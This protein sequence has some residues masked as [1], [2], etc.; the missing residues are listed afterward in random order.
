MYYTT[1]AV[2]TGQFPNAR[3]GDI[4]LE[5][6]EPVSNGYA[7]VGRSSTTKNDPYQVH[8]KPWGIP[9]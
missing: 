5:I 6:L 2:P 9:Q 4:E 7:I 3:G 8:R 1:S